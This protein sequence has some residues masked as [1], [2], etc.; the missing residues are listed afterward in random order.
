MVEG[1]EES[2]VI[3]CSSNLL[4]SDGDNIRSICITRS[5][6]GGISSRVETGE[7][8][9]FSPY[10]DEAIS[11]G[12]GEEDRVLV[13]CRRFVGFFPLSEIGGLGEGVGLGRPWVLLCRLAN[14]MSPNDDLPW[15]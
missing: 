2:S 8:R 5:G 12:T 1:G 3:V 10:F 9:N 11:R 4:N 13:L 6:S 7:D 15:T 14:A